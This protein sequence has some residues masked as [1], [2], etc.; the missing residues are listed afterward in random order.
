MASLK[1]ER[2]ALTSTPFLR[3]S[4]G[5]STIPF[6]SLGDF[7]QMSSLPDMAAL[8][9]KLGSRAAGQ[10]QTGSEAPAV[11]TVDYLAWYNQGRGRPVV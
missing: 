5:A 9:G 4:L 2:L 8:V 10:L 6:R 11:E 1:V 7:H 3:T